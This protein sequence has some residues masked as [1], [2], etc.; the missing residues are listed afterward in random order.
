VRA[1]ALH[2]YAESARHFAPLD[3]GV[4]AIVAALADV[5]ERD[6]SWKL[7]LNEIVEVDA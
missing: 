2:V 3:P 5:P 4:K 6:S 7:L 1:R